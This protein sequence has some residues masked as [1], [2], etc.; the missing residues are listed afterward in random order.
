MIKNAPWF[1]EENS[2]AISEI[3]VAFCSS[4]RGDSDKDT[5]T[6]YENKKT[7]TKKLTPYDNK[8]EKR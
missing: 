3:S 8:K 5:R 4:S 2:A 6:L 7:K 1:I